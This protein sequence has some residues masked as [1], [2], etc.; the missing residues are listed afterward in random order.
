MGCT[1][2]TDIVMSVLQPVYGFYQLF[3]IFKYSNLI[4]NRRRTL[5]RFGL[6]HCISSSLCFW[7]Y[8]ILQETLLALFSKKKKGVYADDNVTY[9]P[10][11]AYGAS[12]YNAVTGYD[13]DDED[14]FELDDDDDE[15]HIYHGT[16]IAKT[17]WSINYGCEKT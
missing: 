16:K 2:T 11:P 5:S 15:S 4:I 1:C 6:M 8:A 9:A 17:S 12:A 14:S 3:F 7:F 10:A 13:D